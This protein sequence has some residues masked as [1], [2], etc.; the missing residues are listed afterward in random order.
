MKEPL[1]KVKQMGG[2][3]CDN[4]TCDYINPD[5][6]VKDYKKWINKSCPLC[7][8]NLLTKTDYK[9]CKRAMRIINI[10]NAISYILPIKPSKTDKTKISIHWNGTGKS[11]VIVHEKG[12]K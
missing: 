6:S 10:V 1:I 11:K 9:S 5:I 12:E 4:P 2:L 8:S 7:G 3:K